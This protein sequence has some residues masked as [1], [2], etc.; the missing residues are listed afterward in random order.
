[1]IDEREEVLEFGEADCEPASAEELATAF[2]ARSNAVAWRSKARPLLREAIAT[3]RTDWASNGM[4]WELAER[5]LNL[6]DGD[7]AVPAEIVDK[8]RPEPRIPR[9]RVGG[10][11]PAEIEGYGEA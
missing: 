11:T 5:L 8:I 1:M 9:L 4:R 6:L 7:G 3:L 2:R 10:E